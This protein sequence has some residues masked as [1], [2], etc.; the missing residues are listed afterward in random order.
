ML[1]QDLDPELLEALEASKAEF[2]KEQKKIADDL[3]EKEKED[4]ELK[5]AIALSLTNH[6]SS[7]VPVGKSSNASNGSGNIDNQKESIRLSRVLTLILKIPGHDVESCILALQAQ[8]QWPNANLAL[9]AYEKSTKEYSAKGLISFVKEEPKTTAKAIATDTNDTN[10]K[11]ANTV[12]KK[13]KRK[14]S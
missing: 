4:E 10:K 8:Q 12:E 7:E 9:E 1:G 6:Q 2:E 5:Q 14:N 13:R 3:L 11:D